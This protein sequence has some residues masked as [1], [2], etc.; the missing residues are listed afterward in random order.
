VLKSEKKEAKELLLVE[1]GE[2]MEEERPWYHEIEQFC[3]DGT[4][5]EEA[6][7]EDRRA[8]RR[9]AIKYT[10]VGEVLYRRA[11]NGMLLRCV[12]DE[13]AW[14][15]VEGSHSGEC[16][17]HVNGQMLAKKILRQGYYWPTL[18]EDCAAYIRRCVRCQIHADK[19]HAPS[20]SL[21]PL[22]SP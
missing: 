20:S 15:T 3:R 9:A 12:T 4:F 6:E 14:K 21:H 22:S 7:A 10:L 18:E 16:R 2:L 1:L 19:I 11:L 13:E 17:G 8:I 5:P